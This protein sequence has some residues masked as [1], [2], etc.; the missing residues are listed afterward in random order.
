MVLKLNHASQSG[1]ALIALEKEYSMDTIKSY[2]EKIQDSVEKV[3][4]TI[5]S[6]HGEIADQVYAQARKTNK[7][8]G[9][10]IGELILKFEKPETA[11]NKAKKAVKEATS[12]AKKKVTAAK[13]ATT[14]ATQAVVEKIED[15]TT[16]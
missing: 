10:R 7:L 12:T 9:K 13:A 15:A 8:I 4:S 16:T 6:K 3:I 14:R 1:F 11:T 2:Q 5:E